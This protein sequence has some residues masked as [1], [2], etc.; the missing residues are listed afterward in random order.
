MNLTLGAAL[1]SQ[2]IAILF[3]GVRMSLPQ[4]AG[5]IGSFAVLGL[6]GARLMFVLFHRAPVPRG[7]TG[8]SP[9]RRVKSRHAP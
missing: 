2:G 9:P 5:M 1:L 4:I 6:V 3:A 8:R 7:G